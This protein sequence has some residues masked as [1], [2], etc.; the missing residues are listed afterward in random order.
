MSRSVSLAAVCILA[1]HSLPILAQ[2]PSA[3]QG[4]AARTWASAGA[5][6]SAPTTSSTYRAQPT[7]TALPQYPDCPIP[8]KTCVVYAKDFKDGGTYFQN[9]NSTKPFTFNQDFEGTVKHP[10]TLHNANRVLGCDS[11]TSYNLLV[12]PNG[13]QSQCTPSNLTPDGVNMRSRWWVNL[14]T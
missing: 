9:I 3:T 14:S 4:S 8:N 11:D 1:F 12:D 5:A 7:N 13:D 2:S 6:S 10:G